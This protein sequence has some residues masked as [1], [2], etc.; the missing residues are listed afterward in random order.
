MLLAIVTFLAGCNAKNPELSLVEK[1][2]DCYK[3]KNTL[4]EEFKS[5]DSSLID[6]ELDTIFYYPK[7]D[8]CA[9]ITMEFYYENKTDTVP[10]DMKVRLYDFFT[11]NLIDEMKASERMFEFKDRIL[12]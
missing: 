2:E 5:D 8:S 10:N 12:E 7:T 1:N 3:Y 4:E 6:F 11:R 9:Y